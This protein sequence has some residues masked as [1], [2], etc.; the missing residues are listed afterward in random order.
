MGL[1]QTKGAVV[2]YCG[3]LHRSLRSFDTVAEPEARLSLIASCGVRSVHSVPS[4][5]SSEHGSDRVRGLLF[6]LLRVSGSEEGTESLDSVV[7]N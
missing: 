6:G 3:S 5:V 2:K 7:F 4:A 1:D